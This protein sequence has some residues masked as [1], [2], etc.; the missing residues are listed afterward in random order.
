MTWIAFLLI[1]IS[2][3]LHAGWNLLL[4]GH[5]P[6]LAFCLLLICLVNDSTAASQPGF[7]NFLYR[8]ICCF[9]RSICSS[10]KR[11]DVSYL[12]INF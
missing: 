11:M 10:A 9:R 2:V 4:K 8:L 12:P 6:S 1:L 7:L 3:F 5:R